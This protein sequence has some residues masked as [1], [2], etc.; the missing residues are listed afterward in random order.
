VRA[1]RSLRYEPH[2]NIFLVLF[3]WLGFETED[4][5]WE[6]LYVL[7]ED[8]PSLVQRFLTSYSDQPLAHHAQAALR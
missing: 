5:S 1:L 2:N 4:D 7:H 6:P 3:S 8:V